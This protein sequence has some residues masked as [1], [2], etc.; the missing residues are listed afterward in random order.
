MN[1]LNKLKS[2]KN[3]YHLVEFL[4]KQNLDEDPLMK[5]LFEYALLWKR[6]PQKFLENFSIENFVSD[7]YSSIFLGESPVIFL[8][9][10]NWAIKKY[11]T[12]E[13]LEA[14]HSNK[15]LHLQNF[16]NALRNTNVYTAIVPE[17]DHL[18]Y[19]FENNNSKFLL[20]EESI[21]NFNKSIRLLG[22][23]PLYLLSN[24]SKITQNDFYYPDSHPPQSMYLDFFKSIIANFEIDLEAVNA[25]FKISPEFFYGDLAAKFDSFLL[26]PY[27]SLAHVSSCNTVEQVSGDK[28]FIEPLGSIHQTFINASPIS[29]DSVLLLGDSHCSIYD[30]KRLTYFF[31]NTF[32]HV[33]FRWKPFSLGDNSNCLGYDRVVL[34]SSERFI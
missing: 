19:R 18:I 26:N 1:I 20:F 33:C 23:N 13:L 5:V 30:Q 24:S 31:A 21:L 2:F 11:M 14:S 8:G 3:Y 15:L 10:N 16:S 25:R 28:T 17:K 29:S 12:Q 9:T 27:L 34:V 7:D 4:S 22:I 6:L 32:R